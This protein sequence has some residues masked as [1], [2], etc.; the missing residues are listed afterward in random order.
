MKSRDIITNCIEIKSIIREYYEQLHANKLDNL[1]ETHKNL[2]TSKLIQ[3][4]I[5]NL[6]RLVTSKRN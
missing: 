1:D 6:D 3:K 2:T 5:E 4:E